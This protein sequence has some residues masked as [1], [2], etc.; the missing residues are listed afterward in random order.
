MAQQ[1]SPSILESKNLLDSQGLIPDSVNAFSYKQGKCL[2]W[3]FTGINT[4]SDS[5]VLE[6]AK[7]PGKGAEAAKRKK[8]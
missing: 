3:D 5:H 6:C 4:I 2:T 7:E 1:H 8:S